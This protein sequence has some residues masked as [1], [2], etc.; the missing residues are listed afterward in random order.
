MH[1][2]NRTG[3]N[4][5]TDG[6]AFDQHCALALEFVAV[7]YFVGGLAFHRFR[8]CLQDVELPVGAVFTPF[9]VHRT[10]IVLFDHQCVTRQLLHIGIGQ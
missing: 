4:L 8:P 5:L 3:T 2:T 9:D 10:T 7:L 6:T 1:D